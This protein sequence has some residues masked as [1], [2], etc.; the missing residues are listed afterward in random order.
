M[1]MLMTDHLARETTPEQDV[2]LQEHL[3]SCENCRREFAEM[4]EIWRLTGEVLKQGKAPDALPPSSHAAIIAAAQEMPKEKKSNIPFWAME[5]AASLVLLVIVGSL[6]LAYNNKVRCN[7]SGVAGGLGSEACIISDRSQTETLKG[8]KANAIEIGNDKESICFETPAT[9]PPAAPEEISRK[10]SGRVVTKARAAAAKAVSGAEPSDVKMPDRL[11]I[12]PSISAMKMP[13]TQRERKSALKKAQA[14]SSSSTVILNQAIDQDKGSPSAFAPGATTQAAGFQLGDMKKA[15]AP[16]SKPVNEKQLA[17]TEGKDNY[18]NL[19][20]IDGHVQGE[21]AGKAGEVISEDRA[22]ESRGN[23]NK[24]LPQSPM[25]EQHTQQI[26]GAAGY[27]H[28]ALPTAK[29]AAESSVQSGLVD[30]RNVATGSFG[31]NT[32]PSDR[33]AEKGVRLEASEKTKR[34]LEK[35]E[36]KPVTGKS[37]GGKKEEDE[38]AAAPAKADASSFEYNKLEEKPAQKLIRLSWKLELKLWDLTTENDAKD[39]LKKHGITLKDGERVSVDKNS[40]K[41]EI[42]GT[43]ETVKALDGVISD[44]LKEEEKLKD[45][46]KG[47]P[48]LNTKEK[49]VSTFS[50]DVDTA[51]YT[52]TRKL[53]LEGRRP[54]PD[55]VRPEEFINYFDYHYRSPEKGMFSVYLDAA[56]SAFRPQDYVLRVGVQ[57]KELGPDE[58]RPS[59]FTVLIDTSGSMSK[60]ERLDLAI[61]SIRMLASKMK[62]SDK[63]SLLS[64]GAEPKT[65]LN[66]IPAGRKSLL[67]N[68][69]DQLRAAGPTDLEKGMIAA[70]SLAS[71]NYI[72]GGYNRVIIFSDGIVGLGSTSAEHILAEVEAARGR[73]ITNTI[74]GLGGDGDESLM[75]KLADK[76]DGSYVFLDSFEEAAQLF[77]KQFAARFREIARDVKIQV[78]FNPSAVSSYRQIGY[79][80]RQLSRADFRDDKVDAGEVGAGQ[81]VTALYELRPGDLRGKDTNIATVRIRYKHAA[82]LEVEE[83]EFSI[84]SGDIKKSH[85]E[86][87]PAF[88]LAMVSGEFAEYLQ[89]PGVPG[90]ASPGAIANTLRFPLSESYSKDSKVIE[91]ERLIKSLN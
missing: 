80:N 68:A 73:G 59:A 69:L 15:D 52:A 9:E 82:T 56:P 31:M 35:P 34:S 38:K 43:V 85:E 30:V 49:P 83:K 20:F 19:A 89:Y 28:A 7:I 87:G 40:N 29:D 84:T 78:E 48:F 86:S 72:A 39:F 41:L 42:L 47:L 26:R 50:I 74:I 53:L 90:L 1:A 61:A 5:L 88:V 71:R 17:E 2:Q 62:P 36:P 24:A 70:Y 64:C 16:A 22:K 6:L 13:M 75:E 79:Q 25:P 37:E 46:K 33:T 55:M 4:Q 32:I 54:S 81:S 66:G 91:L 12:K 10:T 23:I 76:G 14:P 44:L 77:E 21:Y 67:E 11:D 63:I 8:M 60:K 65:L 57:G 27:Q 3:V 18:G 51:S 45:L 58:N